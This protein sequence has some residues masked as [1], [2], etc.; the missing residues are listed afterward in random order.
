MRKSWLEIPPELESEILVQA[1]GH[2]PLETGG[3]LL[4]TRDRRAR[5]AFVSEL[6]DA[7]PRAQRESHRFTP[8]GPWQRARIAERYEASG[9]VL[10]YIGDW[11]SHPGGNGPSPL[12]RS[13]AR[14]IADTPRAL[15]AHPIFLIA[16][17]VKAGWE[18]R[19][20]R[21]GARRFSRITVRR[22]NTMADSS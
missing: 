22:A 20:Y 13:T 14:R 11:H 9:R 8:D 7:G 16:T 10:A 2:A 18:L 3:V 4:G 17:R 19:A 1:G 5:R 12:D 21:F 6:V 15:C